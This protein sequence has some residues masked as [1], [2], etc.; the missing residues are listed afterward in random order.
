MSLQEVYNY[1]VEINGGYHR[2]PFH[3]YVWMINPHYEIIEKH[4]RV[5]YEYEV[6]KKLL[7]GIAKRYGDLSS[8]KAMI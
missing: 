6:V 3:I 8:D 1:D 5:P 4:F 7:D 2:R